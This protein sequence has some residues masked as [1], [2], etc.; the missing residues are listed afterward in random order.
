MLLTQDDQL[1]GIVPSCRTL[2]YPYLLAATWYTSFLE[3]ASLHYSWW[4]TEFRDLVSHVRRV[5]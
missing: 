5:T 1:L 4:S 3:A 2:V